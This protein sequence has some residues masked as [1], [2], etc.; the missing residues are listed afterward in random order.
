MFETEIHDLADDADYAAASQQDHM[1]LKTVRCLIGEQMALGPSGTAGSDISKQSYSIEPENAEIVYLKDNVTIHPTQYATERISGR[2]KLLKQDSLL[3]MSWIPYKGQSS[4]ARLSEKDKNLYTIRAVSFADIRSIR[5]HTPT[6]GWQYVIVVLS[7]GM[8]VYSFAP[9]WNPLYFN[10]ASS[11][12]P[13]KLCLAFPPLYFYNGGVR[14]FIATVKQ[15]LFI[16]RGLIYQLSPQVLRGCKCVSC[17][18]LSR[19]L[20]V[21]L[22]FNPIFLVS[23][24]MKCFINLFLDNM[25]TLSSLEL[26]RTLSI[27]K[28]ASSSSFTNSSSEGGARQKGSDTARD[29]SI[30]VLEKFSLVTR[31]ARETTSQLF[32]ES[33]LDDSR[34]NDNKKSNQSSQVRPR[35]I[36][37]NDVCDTRREVPVPP[38]P[39]EFDKLSLVW[40]QPRQP[41]LSPEEWLTFLGSEGRVEDMTA[42]RKRIFYGGVEHS[43]RKEI[44]AF[45]LGYYAPDSTHA[46]RQHVMAVKKSEY[47]TIKNQWQSISP[48]QAK[49]FTKFRERKGLI[50]RDV[51]R[52]D[53]SLPFY[54]GDENPNVNLLRN[55]LLTYSFYNF[56]LGYCQ[57][58][59]DLL[60]P[61]L[62]TMEDESEAFWCFVSLMERLGPNF[63]RDQNGMHSQ[64]FALSKLVELLDSPL[65]NYFKQ[66][67]CLNYF[68]CFRWILIQFKRQVRSFLPHP[69]L[70][71][72]SSEN[73]LCPL[74][75]LVSHFV[76]KHL[77][78]VWEFEYDQTLRLWEVLWTHHP[79]EHLHLYV[80]IA[81]LKRHRA[82]IMGEQMSFDTLLK[83]INEL[84][85]CID[86]DAVLRDAEAL[87]VCAGENGAASIPPGTPP[88]LPA[89][90]DESIYQQD[91]EPL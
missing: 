76:A 78:L 34:T 39:L 91:D 75:E 35:E 8:A 28:S 50:E 4:N 45:L 6:I 37:S 47:E 58:M 51:V 25:R 85:G 60:S 65:H 38:D 32:R 82:K 3:F 44:W 20:Q 79:S 26:P 61:I 70:W 22:D 74:S 62:F 1:I 77:L 10:I 84:S 27:A 40:G 73:G 53:R 69:I 9:Y 12:L 5:R 63:N 86:L 18:Q 71:N 14:E 43:L 72:C 17:K 24:H 16:V 57:G 11:Q 68:F 54:E 2:L 64:L 23:T 52:T 81:I 88:S 42:L 41:P 80:C 21:Q 67:D 87:C 7:S 33:L 31:F 90:E 48:E 13:V 66:K 30:Q 46:E 15:H 83:F 56:D 49:R 36:A 19:S 59:S 55:I 29:I 89:E